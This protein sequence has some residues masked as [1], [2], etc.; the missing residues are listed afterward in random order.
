MFVKDIIRIFQLIVHLTNRIFYD[1][2]RLQK[3][4]KITSLSLQIKRHL[5]TM[6]DGDTQEEK[7][8]RID[9]RNSLTFFPPSRYS[10]RRLKLSSYS[11]SSRYSLYHIVKSISLA[12]SVNTSGIMKLDEKV[13]GCHDCRISAHVS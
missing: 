11:R 12:L 8:G 6:H 7:K 10:K 1:E 4:S 9:K 3:F 2:S 5:N 13:L